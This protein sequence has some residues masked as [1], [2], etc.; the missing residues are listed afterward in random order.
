M[1]DDFVK[2]PKRA[3]PLEV[4]TTKTE[5]KPEPKPEPE[6][7]EPI[8]D[9]AEDKET[10]TDEHALGEETI[11]DIDLSKDDEP[12]EKKKKRRSPK[13]WFLDLPKK[14]KIL[15]IV[16]MVFVLLGGSAGAYF[17]LKGESPLPTIQSKKKTEKPKPTTV[18]S[19][20]TGLQVAPELNERGVTGI[21]IENHPESWPQSGLN[22]A[23]VVFEA[24]AEGGITR[25]LA[26]YQE[27]Q[28]EY[29]GPIRSA[30]PYYLD[31][32]QGFDAP[33]AH[34]GGSGDAKAKIAS[35]GVRSMDQSANGSSYERIDARY[36]PHNVY[37]SISS[38]DALKA[39]KGWQKSTFTGFARKKEAASKT[40][41]ASSATIAV[42]TGEYVPS[43]TYDAKTNSYLR[44]QAGGPHVDEKSGKQLSSKVV[45][46]M[47]IPWSQQGIY[48]V[49]QNVGSGP[50]VVFQDGVA[51]EG[52]WEKA[53]SK[54]QIVFKDSRGNDL[55]LNPGQTWVSAV[56]A[57][58]DITFTP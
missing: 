5:K 57:R 48:S 6:P 32:L 50:V 58:S 38:L 15:F 17:V 56:R 44:S 12:K 4:P 28:P 20:L 40:P 53:S 9:L 21:M 41:T 11:E 30:R 10:S 2:R 35:D 33:L 47:V 25:F 42:S 49:Y 26:L 19:T 43:Y 18:A 39:V 16:A 13:Q 14:K 3:S 24:I 55:K 31:W 27:A 51:T 7:D 54:D 46:A 34:V 52:I 29:I 22:D 23:G 45:V 36:A 37:T 1:N 8:E